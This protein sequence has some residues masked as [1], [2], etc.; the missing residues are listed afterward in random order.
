MPLN[1]PQRKQ[2]ENW[3]RSQATVKCPACGDSRWRF[4]QAAYLKA[5]LEQGEKD[6]AEDK[7][8]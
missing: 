6:L 2:L 4:A 3:M 7:G 8:W 5:L 1:E